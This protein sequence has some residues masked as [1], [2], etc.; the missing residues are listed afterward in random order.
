RARKFA[1]FP[2]LAQ[3]PGEWPG[4]RTARGGGT[5]GGQHRGD[6]SLTAL[7]RGRLGARPRRRESGTVGPVSRPARADGAGNPAHAQSAVAGIPRPLLIARKQAFLMARCFAVGQAAADRAVTFL[8]ALS[9]I[10]WQ[11]FGRLD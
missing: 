4:A 2:Y 6:Q 5:G 8:M 11:R 9:D 1:S 3:A 7:I 10:A